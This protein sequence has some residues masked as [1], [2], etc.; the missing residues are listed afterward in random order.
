MVT[1]II[2][3]IPLVHLYLDK[4][5]KVGENMTPTG[6]HMSFRYCNSLLLWGAPVP[7][8]NSIAFVRRRTQRNHEITFGLYV[9]D[10]AD[11]EIESNLEIEDA[12]V[13]LMRL[14]CIKSINFRCLDKRLDSLIINFSSSPDKYY[15]F[16]IKDNYYLLLYET[17]HISRGGVQTAF[18]L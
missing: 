2:D 16:G 8:L 17:E 12:M 3:N 4:N 13:Y 10:K 14:D 11:I 18:R 7:Y 9:F 6:F 5:Y 15:S 1:T